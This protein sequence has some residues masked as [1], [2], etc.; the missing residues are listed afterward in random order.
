[1][2]AFFLPQKQ[3]LLTFG[4]LQ[5]LRSTGLANDDS[6][7]QPAKVDILSDGTT[8]EWCAYCIVRENLPFNVCAQSYIFFLVFSIFL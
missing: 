4:A 2:A 3:F 5:T 7:L 8:E 1:M 6:L